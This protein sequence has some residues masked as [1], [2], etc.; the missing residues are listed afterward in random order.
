VP[1]SC[2][3]VSSWENC[4]LACIACNS[5]KGNKSLREIGYTLKKKPRKPDWSPVSDMFGKVP[6]A[7]KKFLP[8]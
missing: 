8:N 3:G 2:G 5:K 1:R 4:V 7:W 6:S